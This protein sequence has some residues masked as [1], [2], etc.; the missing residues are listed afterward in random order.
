M[1]GEDYFIEGKGH[2][3]KETMLQLL[4]DKPEDFS[5]NVVLRPLYQESILPNLA[6]IGGG[7]EIA[8]WLQL[9]GVFDSV[10]V[11]YPLIVVRN[12]MLYID[13]GTAKKIDK[14]GLNLSDVFESSDALKR[15]YVEKNSGEDLDFTDLDNALLQLGEKVTNQITSL[16]PAM[17]QFAASEVVR[18]EKQ[19]EALKDKL[20]KRSKAKHEGAMK[21]IDQIKDRLFPNGKLQERTSN[22][23]SFCPDGMYINKLE[24]FYKAIDP[25]E[26]DFIVLVENES[27]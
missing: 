2:F 8:Y 1:K 22:F 19:I 14:N 12:S 3:K 24:A 6:Y 27:L 10:N 5:P 18:L 13:N 20:V 25:F 15:S 26:K 4:Y 11:T 17:D 23:F 7:G 21:Q 16:D 9:K